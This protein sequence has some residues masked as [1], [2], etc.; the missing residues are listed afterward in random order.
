M[1]VKGLEDLEME[2]G[3]HQKYCIIKI[4]RNTEKSPRNLRRYAVLNLSGN[5]K[6]TW[7][8]KSL[9]YIYIYIYII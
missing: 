7:S 4:D 1:G 6:L 3:D 5:H 9:E 8:E 2:S